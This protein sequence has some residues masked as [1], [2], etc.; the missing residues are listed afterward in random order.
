MTCFSLLY[1]CSII[2]RS[3][4]LYVS[5]TYICIVHVFQFFFSTNNSDLFR[6]TRTFQHRSWNAPR[7]RRIW[8]TE[9][10]L[11]CA[12]TDAVTHHFSFSLKLKIFH[13]RIPSYFFVRVDELLL[14]CTKYVTKCN[15]KKLYKDIYIYKIKNVTLI[16]IDH[17]FW[18]NLPFW[19]CSS[20]INQFYCLLHKNYFHMSLMPKIFKPSLQPHW[21]YARTSW[22]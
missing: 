1:I 2:I 10:F 12:S 3:K 18:S 14:I 19:N 11:R 5:H 13:I 21:I 15:M 20:A 17:S 22:W 8:S 4:E 16:I 7:S 6:Y 9:R